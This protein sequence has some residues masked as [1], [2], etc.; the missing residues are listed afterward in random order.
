MDEAQQ[1]LIVPSTPTSSNHPPP[2][3]HDGESAETVVETSARGD[4]GILEG[5]TISDNYGTN[6]EN[7]STDSEDEDDVNLSLLFSKNI[8]SLKFF[9]L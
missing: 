3:Q 4:E 9:S 1:S 6:G 2:I 7:P 5:A 8:C